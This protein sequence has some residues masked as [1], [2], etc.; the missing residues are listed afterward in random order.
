MSAVRILSTKKLDYGP[1][2]YLLNAGFSVLEADF[3]NTR[4]VAFDFGRVTGNLIF[5]TKNAVESVVLQPGWEQLKSHPVFCVGEKTRA[6]L[7]EKGF[8]VAHWAHY[9]AELAD[10]IRQYATENFTFFCGNLR[11]D[12]M[13][14][15][16]KVAGISF[17]EIEVYE[18]ILSPTQVTSAIDA[19]LFYSP[20][21]VQ[22]YL[23]Q[24]TIGNQICFCIGTTT[25]AAVQPYTS[26][27]VVAKKPTIESVIMTCIKYY[28]SPIKS[29]VNFHLN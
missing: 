15:S 16:M 7:L 14:M 4:P 12:T 27:V 21:G 17:R 19:I 26:R 20:S 10:Q 1:K 13:P 8:S 29:E 5:T 18:T 6:L 24:N 11:M 9:S 25:A 3:I 23:Q 28:E 22:S 2:Q